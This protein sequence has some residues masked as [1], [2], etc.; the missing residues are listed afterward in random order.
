MIGL[1]SGGRILPVSLSFSLQGLVYF[2]F[3]CVCRIG[4]VDT[5]ALVIV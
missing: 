2:V 1:A 4:G 3:V 5:P